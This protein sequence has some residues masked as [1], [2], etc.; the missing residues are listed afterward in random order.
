M[1]IVIPLGVTTPDTSYSDM[2]AGSDPESVEASPAVTGKTIYATHNYPGSQSHG[3]RGLPYASPT[4]QDHNYGA[5][6]P[7]TPPASPPVQAIIPRAELN[8]VHSPEDEENSGDSDS[9]SE[10][11]GIPNWCHCNNSADGFLVKC[12]KCRGVNRGKVIQLNRRKQDNVSGG[13]SSATESWDEEL[14]PSTVLYTATQHTPTSITLTVNRVRRS[15]PKKRKKSTEKARN[16]PKTKKIK[17][18]REGSRKSL[19]MKNSPSDAHTLD[20]NTTE[21]W[22]NRIRLWTDQYEEAFTNQYSADMQN[23][24]ERHVRSNK[25]LV[26]K[27]EL[28]ETIKKT[29]LS[30]NNTVVGSQM[31]LGRVAR[32][33]KHRKILRASKDLPVNTLVIEYRGK[34][35]LRQQFEVNGHFFKK[36]YPF[37]LFYSKFNGLEMC[38]D[39][40]TFGNDAR[41]IRRSCTPN[42]EVRHVIADGMVHLCIYAIAAIAKDTE[43]TIAF[44]FDYSNCSYKVDCA[45]HKG[46]RN[47]PVQKRNPITGELPPPL[48]LPLSIGAETRHRKARRR[49]LE[50]QG[51]VVDEST[52]HQTDEVAETPATDAGTGDHE[53]EGDIAVKCEDTKEE[54]VGILPRTRRSRDEKKAELPVHTT[55]SG[56]R[57]RRRKEQPA[58]QAAIEPE[59]PSV[60]EVQAALDPTSQADDPEPRS[61][62]PI[63]VEPAPNPTQGVNTR[64]S[65]QAQDINSEKPTP[66]P[67]PPKSTRPRP[68]SRMSRYRSASAQRLRR[69]RQAVAQQVELAPPVPE[70]GTT[71]SA[72]T[73]P[74]TTENL[75]LG[76]AQQGSESPA[77]TQS[78]TQPARSGLK[79]HKTKK[80]LVTEWL[81]DKVEKQDCP[82][83]HPLRITTDPTV[84][85]TTLNMLPGLSHSPSICTAPKH[86]IRFVSPYMPERRRR[87]P[88]VDGT[89]GSCK[90]RWIKQAME[91]DF[92]QPE[93]SVQEN[94]QPLYQ[95][96]E[97]TSSSNDPSGTNT[98]LTAPFKKWKM[99]YILEEN[100]TM[101]SSPVQFPPALLNSVTTD[102]LSPMQTTPSS[103]LPGE[104]ESRYPYGL[105]F[106]PIPSLA[107]SRCNTPLQFE[108]ISSPESSPVHRPESLSPE[109]CLRTDT[110]L[111][112]ANL[113][114][115]SIE[116]CQEQQSTIGTALSDPASQSPS[117]SLPYSGA[118]EVNVL[119]KGGEGSTLLR[120]SEQTFRTEFNL[121]YAFSPLNAM[122]RADGSL[123][124]SP[125]VGERK[126]SQSDMYCGSPVEAYYTRPVPG[127]LK[128]SAQGS[129]SPCSERTCEGIRSSP[130]NQPQRK[131]KVSL[132]E[133]RKRKQEA[134]E[135]TS[136]PGGDIIRCAGTPTRQ[137][138]N[139]SISDTD[140]PSAL[141]LQAPSSPPSGF[142]SPVHPS[143]PQIEDVSPTERTVSSSS[144]SKQTES[145]SSRWMVPTSVE[146]LR[147]GQGFL[148]RVLRSGVKVLQ[149][150]EVSPSRESSL[151]RESEDGDPEMLNMAVS[152]G[153]TVYSPSRYN[154]P[155]LQCDSPQSEPVSVLSQNSSPF[156]GPTAQPSGYTY[157]TPQRTGHS[158]TESSVISSS[159]SSPPHITSTDS[160]TAQSSGYYNSQQQYGSNAGTCPP[161]KSFQHR[162]PSREASPAQLLRTDSVSSDSQASTGASTNSSTPQ[163]S[164]SDSRTITVSGSRITAVSSPQHYS[165]RGSGVHQYRLQQMQASGVKTQTGLS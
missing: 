52:N 82:I 61:E 154:Y 140:L 89:Y 91:D 106:S 87:P 56:E 133:Y 148:E 117:T 147:E 151:D 164:R 108:N 98:D 120:T 112:K 156:R 157:R 86:Y 67:V 152:K 96:N 165:Q 38:V 12:E 162:G 138:S 5:P 155:F 16:T 145:I 111:P 9:S 29:E 6:P 70:E 143:M 97:N 153:P 15:K 101:L 132:L 72:T 68:K 48:P 121:M 99:K 64:R 126:P 131:K 71:S 109:P 50:Q 92:S 4:L 149:R 18:F 79:Y 81:N 51:F 118:S 43:V 25:D 119:G 58:E 116:N 110:D 46:N 23:L 13:E 40:R 113:L 146:R 11:E 59:A 35:M 115:I 30:C 21:G 32:V 31:Q 39:A 14:S 141:Q 128:E 69:Q 122:P 139:G 65:S 60:P 136:S 102:S 129:M 22:E 27:A 42:A 159:F 144:H 95:S 1:S 37:V 76:D 53:A 66:K 74:G 47:C 49:E 90:K 94:P 142:S 33:Q 80:Y 135:V 44:D 26:G 124:G 7:P 105:M 163:G 77:A 62:S 78:V 107:T 104:E 83:D 45:C 137:S 114:D 73:E 123:R 55:D 127:L 10:G 75:G 20:E 84:L 8:G 41:F 17:A 3:Y 34:V 160:P 36:P 161:R 134:K 54:E 85:A 125:L 19:R 93:S 88:K 158:H 63:D 2:A 150:G 24:L 28:P 57:R 130:Q 100:S 103:S